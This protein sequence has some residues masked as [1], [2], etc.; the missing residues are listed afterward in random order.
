MLQELSLVTAVLGDDDALA[1]ALGP[2]GKHQPPR[3]PPAA[4]LS[5]P[6]L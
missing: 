2:F 3:D 5:P 1:E 4:C 6:W